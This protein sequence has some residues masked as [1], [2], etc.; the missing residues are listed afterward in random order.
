MREM[1]LMAHALDRAEWDHLFGCGKD[2]WKKVCMTNQDLKMAVQNDCI[3]FGIASWMIRF[4]FHLLLPLSSSSLP[5]ID[6]G[7]CFNKGQAL[8]ERQHDEHRNPSYQSAN[9]IH[10]SFSY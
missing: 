9:L 3:S 10:K 2:G 7:Q 6:M 1:L 5:D 4:F 8:T